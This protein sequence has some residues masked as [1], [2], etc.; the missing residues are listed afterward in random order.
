[1][2]EDILCYFSFPDLRLY[3][4]DALLHQIM[5]D[6]MNTCTSCANTIVQ[7]I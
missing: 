6:Y 5:P 4:V 1:M 7:C 3:I 2:V